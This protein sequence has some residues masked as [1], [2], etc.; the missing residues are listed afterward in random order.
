MISSFVHYFFQPYDFF[1]RPVLNIVAVDTTFNIYGQKSRS[2]VKSI[3]FIRNGRVK[4]I[5]DTIVHMLQIADLLQIAPYAL[6]TFIN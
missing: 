5:K 1:Y 3:D 6:R 2:I 4:K